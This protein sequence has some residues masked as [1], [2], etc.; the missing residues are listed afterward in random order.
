MI[1]PVVDADN[2]VSTTS[3][4][5]SIL[6]CQ[7]FRLNEPK[8]QSGANFIWPANMNDK[9]IFWWCPVLTCHRRYCSMALFLSWPLQLSACRSQAVSLRPYCS[10]S[11]KK[12]SKLM[13]VLAPFPVS[14]ASSRKNIII[15]GNA[16]VITPNTPHFLG[17]L[18]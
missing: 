18:K 16:S 13:T 17:V 4:R 9:V 15:C 8:H 5:L 10:N 2:P 3:S 12:S 6:V 1:I 7:N 11:K 14:I